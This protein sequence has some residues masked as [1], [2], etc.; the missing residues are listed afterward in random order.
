MAYCT[1][2]DAVAGA[3][4]TG[5]VRAGQPAAFCTTVKRD[6]VEVVDGQPLVK[7]STYQSI[8]PF[9]T[10]TSPVRG[11]VVVVKR[12]KAAS[13]FG[14]QSWEDVGRGT[15]FREKRTGQSAPGGPSGAAPRR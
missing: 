12:V 1:P 13:L 3:I 7:A 6:G 8:V 4:M 11:D 9:G 14:S 15:R 10:A 2:D 5:G